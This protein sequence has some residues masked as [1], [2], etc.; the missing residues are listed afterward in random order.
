MNPYVC[1]AFSQLEKNLRNYD[2]AISLLENVM[3]SK[4]TTELCISLSEIYSIVGKANEAKETLLCGLNLKNNDRVKLL[5][6]LASLEETSFNN[7]NDAMR[8]IN[9]ALVLDRKS[10][11]IYIAKASIEL[12][13][14]DYEAARRTLREAS[15]LEA[16]DGKHFTLWSTV[17]LDT[18]NVDEARRVLSEGA[19]KFPGDPFLLQR[20]GTVEAKYGSKVKARNL[21]SKSIQICPHAP[22]FVAWAILEESEIKRV[23]KAAIDS[24]II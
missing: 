1:H 7:L 11:R 14:N 2:Q 6:S 19:E 8:L 10:V 22:T 12:R 5:L 17:E 3:R 13:Q 23:R 20:W 15:K 24:S 18:G 21:F 9:E 16:S 4:P